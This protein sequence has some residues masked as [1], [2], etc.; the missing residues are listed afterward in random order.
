MRGDN[1]RNYLGES[2]ASNLRK[3][4]ADCCQVNSNGLS[5]LHTMKNSILCYFSRMS[6]CTSHDIHH[7]IVICMILLTTG[8]FVSYIY[9]ITILFFSLKHYP[10]SLYL[11]GTPPG[12]IAAL[13][14]HS[15]YQESNFSNAPG[16]YRT[17]SEHHTVYVRGLTVQS[18]YFSNYQAIKIQRFPLLE[19]VARVGLDC[20]FILKLSLL[21][22]S[23]H[24]FQTVYI[25]LDMECKCT[26]W[27][28]CHSES[29]AILVIAPLGTVMA[30]V[31]H[32][33][34]NDN[35]ETTGK[36]IHGNGK[37]QETYISS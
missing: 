9:N 16:N 7:H 35:S 22:S 17:P 1:A 31:T 32:V 27:F 26:T 2:A 25:Y 24:A 20:F 19:E 36:N 3:I 14:K 28:I 34:G 12:Y 5:L 18:F 6:Y 21:I 29:V 13:C 15:A 37:T 10:S 4:D 8:C 33:G 23:P 30:S 11:H